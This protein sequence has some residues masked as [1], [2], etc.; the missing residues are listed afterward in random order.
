MKSDNRFQILTVL[1]CVPLGLTIFESLQSNLTVFSQLC[2]WIFSCVQTKQGS[3]WAGQSEGRNRGV[4]M[5]E[6][7]LHWIDF[8]VHRQQVDRVN[9]CAV[10]TRPES[11]KW[12]T[13][14][15]TEI[16]KRFWP[17]NRRRIRA[18]MESRRIAASDV[19]TIGLPY[20]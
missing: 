14:T 13:S 9:Y 12:K 17:T 2:S 10:S 5:G 20:P 18:R 4:M 19:E 8:K 1:I 15:M 7:S 16:I 11:T 6:V 3:A